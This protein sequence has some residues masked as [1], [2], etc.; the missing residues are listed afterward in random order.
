MPEKN[1][2]FNKKKIGKMKRQTHRHTRA[3]FQMR[4]INTKPKQ[5]HDV[6]RG[7]EKEKE[8]LVER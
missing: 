2:E 5:Q 3:L 7:R 6:E 8:K 1:A 4:R